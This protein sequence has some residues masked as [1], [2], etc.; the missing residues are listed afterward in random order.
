MVMSDS[1]YD[2]AKIIGKLYNE[3]FQRGPSSGANNVISK[4]ALANDAT[5]LSEDTF[6]VLHDNTVT[7]IWGPG[8]YSDMVNN[9]ANSSARWGE[10]RWA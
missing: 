2:L 4:A 1:N 10:A 8:G 6:Q 7:W 9:G 5:P 3:V